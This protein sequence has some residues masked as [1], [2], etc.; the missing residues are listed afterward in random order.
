[1]REGFQTYAQKSRYLILADFGKYRTLIV[2]IGRFSTADPMRF[3]KIARYRTIGI[4][5]FPIICQY[6]PTSDVSVCFE[7]F[8]FIGFYRLLSAIF[9]DRQKSAKIGF[10]RLRYR[11]MS[12]DIG[13][14]SGKYR[15]I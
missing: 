11:T 13:N 1:M 2:G 15:T 10:Y 5:F 3:G 14:L 4:R 9:E 8:H 7:N 12:D 6:R